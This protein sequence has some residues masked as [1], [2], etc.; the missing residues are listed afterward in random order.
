LL[1]VVALVGDRVGPFYG[2]RKK[3]LYFTPRVRQVIGSFVSRKRRQNGGNLCL[4]SF[5]Y[6][7]LSH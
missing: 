7:H 5:Y 1:T 4:L 2:K 6:M 3:Q